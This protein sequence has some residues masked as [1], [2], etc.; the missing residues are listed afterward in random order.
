MDEDQFPLLSQHLKPEERGVSSPRFSGISIL[1]GNP[2]GSI[3][4][5]HKEVFVK[6]PISTQLAKNFSR[7]HNESPDSVL[8]NEL[9]EDGDFMRMQKA[10]DLL[11]NVPTL[12]KQPSMDPFVNTTPNI[13]GVY[14]TV[15]TV[16]LAPV[17]VV[18]ML[19]IG[20]LL[21][22]G[23][24]NTKVALIGWE[25]GGV[26]QPW[27]RKLMG[28]TRLCARGILYC[29]GFYWIRR[30]GKPACKDVAPIVVSNHVSFIDPLFYFYELFPSI[31]SSKAHDRF[32]L[33]GTIIRSM[34][35]I[36]VDKLSAESR[37]NATLEIK[38]RAASMEFPS[39]LLFP[40]G[41]TTNGKA[42]IAFKQG[43]FAPGFP[44]QPVVIRYPFAHFDISWGDISLCDVLFRMLTQ[45]TNFMEQVEYLPVIYPSAR[46]VQNPSE[47]SD[48]VRD[49]MAHALGV[50]VTEHTHGDLMLSLHA[51]R[52][53]LNSPSNYMVE[54]GRVEKVL[55]LRAGAVKIFLEKFAAMNP[56]SCG[57]VSLNQFVKWHHMPKCWM[58]KKIFDLFDKSGQGF[59]TFREFVAVM[60]SI[61]KSKEFKSQMKAAYDAC[62]LQNSDCIS[63]LELEKCLKLS[64]PTISS[65]YV[66]AWFSKISQHDDGAISWEDFQVFL[67][68]N[69]E[70]LPIFM[71]GT[72]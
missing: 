26:L 51:R 48:R 45:F 22:V 42:L 57:T 62:N 53:C 11:P 2:M 34:Q 41:T 67:E 46:E 5:L 16:L 56:T 69:P 1:V 44:I 64:M 13:T 18:R 59:T 17:A 28:F 58:S 35:V 33:V 9:D 4:E 14:E 29:F 68:T 60:G 55:G 8:K 52:L 39:V 65:A 10:L 70:L 12:G 50:P 27:R 25:K 6:I 24:L 54:L 47:F 38:R 21:L 15:K 40:E 30:V 43:A 23:F 20:L 61:T 63:Q 19:L 32:Y 37:K 72:F 36:P 31:V 3:K 66:R 7:F 71:V 49:E